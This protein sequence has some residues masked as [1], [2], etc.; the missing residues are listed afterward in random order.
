MDLRYFAALGA[1]AMG[2]FSSPA[3]AATYKSP[4]A[5]L[6]PVIYYSRYL[7]AG[8]TYTFETVGSGDP[9]MHLIEFSN[10]GYLQVASNDDGGSGLN[11]RITYTPEKSGSHRL[12]VRSYSST[13]GGVTDLE[14]D[15]SV[16]LNNTPFGSQVTYNWQGGWWAA[17]DS[18]RVS[19]NNYN[20]GGRR[21]PIV[22]ALQNNSYVSAMNDDSGPNYYP[23]VK[24]YF[25]GSNQSRI[26]WGA[27]PG[28]VATF[29]TSAHLTVD[30]T[31]PSCWLT[32]CSNDSDGDRLTND[33]ETAV[34]LDPNNRDSDRDGI[35]DGVEL[36]GTNGFSM[37]EGGDPFR[38][39]IFIEVDV[40]DDPLVNVPYADL[41][42]DMRDVFDVDGDTDMTVVV[43][44]L[45]TWD[46]FVGA[47]CAAGL[48]N[49]TEF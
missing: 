5:Q 39:S 48:A 30:D 2:W 10:G 38:P 47:P 28:S 20:A 41:D 12:L 3:D 22:F 17:G 26:V 31:L 27:Y 49:C 37:S 18:I 46:Q 25:N 34:G 36:H 7:R 21:D 29:P 14:V 16:R 32:R 43:D 6:E 8:Q 45:I 40:M 1:L 13:R 19:A 35:P 33:F 42:A 11:S 9:V 15:G 24:P 44:D 4:S 23:L